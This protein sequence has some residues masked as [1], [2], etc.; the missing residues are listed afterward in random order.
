MLEHTAPR[1]AAPDATA[2][3][4]EEADRF[5]VH[6]DVYTSPEVFALELERIF[7]SGWVYVAHE[8]EIATPGDYK[9][10]Y[11]GRYPVIVSR[12]ETGSINVLL[13]R[14]RHRG[15]VV[16][17]EG[18]GHA[19]HFRCI[20]HNWVY[21]NDGSL[22]GMSQSSGYPDDFDKGELSLHRAPAVGTYRGLIFASFNA[23]VEP[24]EQRLAHV[25]RYID[26][27]SD[28]APEG[29][30]SLSSNVH[31]YQYPANWKLQIEN[32]VDGYHG[33]YVHESF[34]KVLEWSGETSRKDVHRKRNAVTEGNHAKGLPYGD[35]LLER[36]GGTL[37]TF[38]YDDWPEYHD[39]LVAAHGEDGAEE[40]MVQRNVL[41][42]PNVVLFESHVRVARP[43]SVDS[44][45]VD[46]YFTWFDGAPDDLN[47]ARLREH[48]RFFGP[49]SFGATDDVEIFVQVATGVQGDASPWLDLSRGLHREQVV[50]EERLGHS[51]DESTQ[52]AIYRGWRDAMSGGDDNA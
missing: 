17:R 28:R 19:N 41:I 40:A 6:S 35:A 48:E 43:M 30:I 7:H 23:E 18:R 31:R 12:D 20:Y 1:P 27:W 10:T 11:I 14:C 24:L 2:L 33:N 15:A 29:T 47:T 32:G 38:D 42:F 21:D 26:A 39:A 50:G 46:N 16:C 36:R 49:S 52:R 13:N 4:A 44:T 37:G 5:R 34:T 9:S 22:A 51:T 45:V 8:S 3:V 25:R